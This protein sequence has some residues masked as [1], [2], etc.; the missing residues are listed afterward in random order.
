VTT[1]AGLSLRDLEYVVAVADLGSFVRAAEHC[2]VSQPSL[3]AQVRKI[4]AWLG[5]PVFERTTRRVFETAAGEL[6]IQ[7]AR[8][9]LS[10]ARMLR[11]VAESADRPF[12]GTLRLSAISTLGPYLFPKILSDLRVAYPELTLVL[13]EGLT[14]PLLARLRNGELDAVLVSDFNSDPALSFAPIFREPFLMACPD[15]HSVTLTA[16]DAWKSLPS[17]ERLLLEDGHC[18]RDQA[19]AACAD[20]GKRDRHGTSLETLKYMVAAGEGCTLM[21]ALAAEQGAGIRYLPLPETGFTRTIGLAW[22]HSDGRAAQFQQLSETLRSLATR[23]AGL[24][25]ARFVP[26]PSALVAAG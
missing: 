23:I 2:N 12:G 9:V 11:T 7:Q 8:R 5:R 16:E 25:E 24:R 15:G 1:L 10:E 18:L 19:L 20:V 14:D 4:E 21:P 6:F 13:G 3:S 17:S 26:P 22:R